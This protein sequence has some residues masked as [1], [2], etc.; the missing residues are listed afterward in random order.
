MEKAT[1]NRAVN[2]YVESSTH[3]S[4]SEEVRRYRSCTG[5]AAL[6]DALLLAALLNNCGS[7]NSARTLLNPLPP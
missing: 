5:T 2:V 7:V 6:F 1:S 3:G 4:E